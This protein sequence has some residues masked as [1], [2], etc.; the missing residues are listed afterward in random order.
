MAALAGL[1]VGL[2]LLTRYAFGWLIL[3]TVAFMI[4][5]FPK[6]RFVLALAAGLVF[7]AVVSPWI[8]RNYHWSGAPFGTATY[9]AVQG[10]DAF[11]GDQ[12]ERSLAPNW[13]KLVTLDDCRRKLALNLADIL[14]NDLP[15]LGGSWVGALFLVGLLVPFV[16]P[17]L[18]R[19]RGFLL[20]AF[21]VFI[22]AQALG[23]TD[24]SAA[25]PEV[26]S[27]NLLVILFP[28][29]AV[30]GAALLSMLV[31]QLDLP[32]PPLR[33]ATIGAVVLILSAPF[34]LTL[35]PPRADPRAYPPYYPP[36]IQ[37]VSKWMGEDELLMSDM[38]WAVAWYGNRPCVALPLQVR[39]PASRNDYF[40]VSASLK[41]VWAIYL[42]QITIDTPLISKLCMEMSGEKNPELL[43]WNRFMGD[44]LLRANLPAGFP[45][46]SALSD[47]LRNGQFLLADRARWRKP[48]EPAA[49][50]PESKADP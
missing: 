22:V 39:D 36:A 49:A 12:L 35:L 11:P 3:P 2:G 48:A 21:V 32:F 34:I 10:T 29:A 14:R 50:E 41:P 5:H 23:R 13:D 42:T 17:T 7:V 38:P 15:R 37:Q 26:N 46:K 44:A 18:R 47:Y 8:A 25:S 4:F 45:L 43:S 20:L 16:N 30:F 28:M 6:R 31:A 1:I 24:L 27:E 33:W 9:A 19:L 40:A